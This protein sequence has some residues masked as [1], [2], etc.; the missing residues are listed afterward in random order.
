MNEI[1][2]WLITSSAPF[3]G[4]EQYYGAYAK[5][6]DALED[7]LYSN[8]FNEE[9]DNLYNEYG[10]FWEDDYDEEFEEVKEDY[11]SYD[12]FF[13]NK[14]NEWC[15]NCNL[16]VEECPEEDFSDYVSGG[17]GELEIIYDERK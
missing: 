16:S 5:D 6:K 8:W 11:E 2:S 7:W 10:Y 13:D 9:C 1:K 15:Q 14:Y 3:C 12:D 4:T 17:N